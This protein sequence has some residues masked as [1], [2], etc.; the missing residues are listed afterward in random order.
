LFTVVQGRESMSLAGEITWNLMPPLTF[1][2]DRL[3][4]SC[5]LAPAYDVGEARTCAGADRGPPSCHEA[6]RAATGWACPS[7][8]SSRP[9][10]TGGIGTPDETRRS[11]PPQP[12]RHPKRRMVAANLVT[13]NLVSES[14]E[15]E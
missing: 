14:L 15:G 4:I 3:V 1:G 12:T 9:A 11:Y 8:R 6:E 7:V 5:V 10:G 13:H 2:T